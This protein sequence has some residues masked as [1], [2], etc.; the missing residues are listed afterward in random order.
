MLETEIGVGFRTVRGFDKMWS[1]HISD[2]LSVTSQVGVSKYR[3]KEEE[4]GKRRQEYKVGIGGI[5][6]RWKVK[7]GRYCKFLKNKYF[8]Y[9]HC[10]ITLTSPSSIGSQSTIRAASK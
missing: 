4:R 7:K 10:L 2:S 5:T 3:A 1:A 8:G 6:I 9:H